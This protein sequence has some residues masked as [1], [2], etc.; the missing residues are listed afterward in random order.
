MRRW[1]ALTAT[2]TAGLL[3]SCA[4]PQSVVPQSDSAVASTVMVS[5]RDITEVVAL[6]STVV[7]APKFLVLAPAAGRVRREGD[8]FS[9][10]GQPAI[11]AV[12][13]TLDQWL[14]PDG[15]LVTTG[16]PVA[17]LSYAGF[18]QVAVL[19]PQDAYRILSGELR[20][21]ANIAGG[22][23][24]FDCVVLPAPPESG[25]AILCAIP[26]DVKAFAG[27]VGTVAVSSRQARQVLALPVTAVSGT[28]QAGEVAVVS[29]DGRIE[30]RKVTLGVTDGSYVEIVDGLT[31]GVSVLA[32]AP[33]L[34][35]LP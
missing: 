7:A 11:S 20:A 24:P 28:V 22:P 35:G 25:A 2:V 3:A 13:G 10:N 14:V 15:A 27:L 33:P 31:D 32:V 26:S 23:G 12:P 21:R 9:V 16:I 4:T 18:G 19:P 5:R 34:E 30:V 17:Q 1:L 8:L 6:A 29:A